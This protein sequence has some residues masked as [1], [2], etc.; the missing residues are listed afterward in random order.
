MEEAISVYYDL[1]EILQR[2]NFRLTKWTTNHSKVL[3]SIPATERSTQA[4]QYLLG[5]SN[6][7]VLGI[8]WQVHSDEFTFDVHLP[9]RPLTRSILSTV[10][11]LYNPLGFAG[12]VILEAK[13][14]L[15]QLCKQRIDWDD[16]IK[17]P[18]VRSWQLWQEKLLYLN[19]I[20]VPR[21][22]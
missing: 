10:A 12:P 20:K 17:D 22:F 11:S 2:R 8:N 13:A 14:L 3:Q 6:D 15:Q 5:D 7:R 21:C 1:T 16:P 4:Q 18:D 19:N 9:K